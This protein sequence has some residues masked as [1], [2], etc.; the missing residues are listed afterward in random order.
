MSASNSAKASQLTRGLWL[1]SWFP[2]LKLPSRNWLIFLGVSSTMGVAI[3]YDKY[4]TKLIKDA[5]V[6]RASAIGKETADPFFQ[7]RKLIVYLSPSE[8]ARWSFKQHVKPVLD[9]AAIDYD[10]FDASRP[11]KIQEN[12]RQRFFDGKA[13][14]QEQITAAKAA[15]Q[16]AVSRM[17]GYKPAEPIPEPLTPQELE[18]FSHDVGIVAVGRDAWRELLNGVNEGSLGDPESLVVNEVAAAA[19]LAPSK[20]EEL[21]NPKKRPPMHWVSPDLLESRI[22]PPKFEYPPIGYIRARNFPGFRNFP[23][24]V[25]EFFNERGAME[26]A[27]KAALMVA[28]DNTRKAE[29]EDVTVDEEMERRSVAWKAVREKKDNVPPR[30]ITIHESVLNKLKIY[31]D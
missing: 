28:F 13:L 6:E 5:F 16:S 18:K 31:T 7:P 8:I 20:K 22:P 30:A 3:A 11:G 2:K 19:A 24:R 26:S 27:G 4:R 12:I 9:A 29:T 15:P 14:Y 23:A 21:K 10:V 17:L 1:S 25:V